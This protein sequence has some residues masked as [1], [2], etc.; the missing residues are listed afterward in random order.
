MG[1]LYAFE[2]K[3]ALETGVD[4]WYDLSEFGDT[5]NDQGGIYIVHPKTTSDRQ[6]EYIVAITTLIDPTTS[7]LLPSY[8]QNIIGPCTQFS[9]SNPNECIKYSTTYNEPGLVY[10]VNNATKECFLLGRFALPDSPSADLYDTF[11]DPARGITVTY[12]SGSWC[13]VAKKN[14]EFRM[15]LV[16]PRDHSSVFDPSEE[17]TVD[18]LYEYVEE[19]ETCIYS[20]TMTSAVACPYQCITNTTDAQNKE[21]FTVCSTNGLCAADP[22]AGFVRC[23]CDDGWKG[24]YCYEIDTLSPTLSPTKAIVPAPIIEESSSNNGILKYVIVVLVIV[25]LAVVIASYYIYKNQKMRISHKR[26]K[27]IFIAC[28]IKE[29]RLRALFNR[30]WYKQMWLLI[31]Q[32]REDLL[33]LKMMMQIMMMTIQQED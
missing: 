2:F 13:D 6:Y 20:F 4:V 15:N 16:C 11:D 28:Q 12:S 1:S 27:L 26:M 8:C 18:N 29:T 9:E 31:K 14:R 7:D 5:A 10:Q 25:I 22:N 21:A 3:D 23:L 33:Q 24:V 17:T 32:E 30:I 19:E